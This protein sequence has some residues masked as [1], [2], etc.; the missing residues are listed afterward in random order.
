[1]A[2]KLSV[3]IPVFNEVA[4]IEEVIRRVETVSLP[5]AITAREMIAVNDGSAD[6]TAEQLD[7]PASPPGTVN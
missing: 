4:T 2:V 7:K 5:R 3:I 1:M 6:G